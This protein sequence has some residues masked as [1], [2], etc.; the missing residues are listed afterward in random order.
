MLL[1]LFSLVDTVARVLV[2]FSRELLLDSDT[3]LLDLVALEPR[4]ARVGVTV[5][6]LDLVIAE[7]PEAA[8][9]VALLVVFAL[10]VALAVATLFPL[11]RVALAL[12]IAVLLRCTRDLISRSALFLGVCAYLL[13]LLVF[14]LPTFA[15]P[16]LPFT[17]K[18]LTLFAYG[19]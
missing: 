10:R 8:L 6:L 11:K 17:L 3:L 13:L 5:L 18:C 16:R 1:L 14:R 9:V 4:F 2:T 12:A 15:L 19:L 7:L